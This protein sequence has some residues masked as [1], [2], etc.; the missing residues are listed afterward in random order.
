MDPF[1]DSTTYNH[2]KGIIH[3]LRQKNQYNEKYKLKAQE[4]YDRIDQTSVDN[5]PAKKVDHKLSDR[6]KLKKKSDVPEATPSTSG[7]SSITNSD[8]IYDQNNETVSNAEQLPRREDSTTDEKDTSVL[9]KRPEISLGVRTGNV[10]ESTPLVNKRV[11]D[12]ELFSLVLIEQKRIVKFNVTGNH[13]YLELKKKAFSNDLREALNNVY[14]IFKSLLDK[15]L[16]PSNL[17]DSDNQNRDLFAR[18]VI[19]SKFFDPPVSLRFQNVKNINADVVF[20]EIERIVRSSNSFE[21]DDTFLVYVVLCRPPVGT[22]KNCGRKEVHVSKLYLNKRCVI[23]ACSCPHAD[24][25]C[26]GRSIM[27][28]KA[29]ADYPDT[30]DSVRKRYLTNRFSDSI[31]EELIIFHRNAGILCEDRV[32]GFADLQKFQ[33]FL[34]PEYRIFLFEFV[35]NLPECT[36]FPQKTTNTE[37]KNI[38]IL[39]QDCHFSTI[40][41]IQRFVGKDKSYCVQCNQV[42]HN[43]TVYKH[44]DCRG[45]CKSCYHT[46]CPVTRNTLDVN[47]VYCEKCFRWFKND[48]CFKL[49]YKI[50]DKRVKSSCEM[51]YNCPRCGKFCK[52]KP[53]DDKHVCGMVKCTVCCQ[54][55]KETSD[56]QHVCFIQKYFNEDSECDSNLKKNRSKR[57][58]LFFFDIES[59]VYTGVHKPVCLIFCN[60]IGDSETFYG[61]DCIEQFCDRVFTTDF[62]DSIFLSHN[63]RSYDTW[64]ILQNCYKNNI[65]P[66]MIKSGS[67]ILELTIPGINLSFRDNLNFMLLKLE[68]LPKA[69]GFEVDSIKGVF[70]YTHPFIEDKHKVIMLPDRKYFC[71]ENMSKERLSQFD[72]WYSDRLENDPKYHYYKE[73]TSYCDN[74]VQILKKACIRFR[75]E[76][77]MTAGIC[78]YS[79]ALTLAMLSSLIYRKNY[80]PENTIGLIPS[81]GFPNARKYSE[82]STKWLE[83]LMTQDKTLDIKHARNGNERQ[84]KITIDN[85]QKSVYVDGYAEKNNKIQIFEFLGCFWHAHDS[86]YDADEYSPFLGTTFGEVYQKTTARLE[87]LK[88]HP[89]VSSVITIW[90]CEYDKKIREDDIFR[91]CVEGI[92]VDTPLTPKACLVGGRVES[93]KLYHEIS[94]DRGDRIRI[95]DIKS[96]YPHIMKSNFFPI[97]WPEIMINVDVAK[98]DQIYG[99]MKCTILP[100]RSLAVPVLP[101]KPSE[102]SQLFYPLCA[103]CSE[104]KQKICDHVESQRVL[105]STWTTP[106]LQLAVEYG[107]KIIRIIEAWHFGEKSNTLFSQFVCDYYATKVASEGFPDDI[108]TWDEQIAYVEKLNSLNGLNLTVS[109]I[110]KNKALRYLHKAVLNSLFGRFIISTDKLSQCK[111]IRDKRSFFSLIDNKEA[112]IKEID[113][114]GDDMLMVRYSD[115]YRRPPPFTNFVIGSFITSLARVHLYRTCYAPLDSSQ[116]LYSDTDSV[117]M[118]ERPGYPSLK[119]SPMEL[120]GLCDDIMS[121]FNV[122]DYA[123][124]FVSAAFKSYGYQLFHNDDLQ[125]LKIKGFTLNYCPLK[126]EQNIMTLLMLIKMV[127]ENPESVVVM[128]QPPLFHK[129][130]LTASITTKNRSKVF[131]FCFDRKIIAE[132]NEFYTTDGRGQFAY[133]TFPYGFFVKD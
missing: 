125:V 87:A 58:R 39:L 82:K 6:S 133:R 89:K 49:H 72:E 60:E 129:N 59:E 122:D 92:K 105:T 24:T 56:D 75:D 113:I 94:P 13:Y 4:A 77:I 10:N 19:T 98:F 112:D 17:A 8:V 21:L 47:P 71:P 131:S 120:G 57:R 11:L 46:S 119:T 43:R 65:K 38:Y 70:P 54:M 80:M 53:N 33:D 106:E 14:L 28:G 18:L 78:P 116:L 79:E 48:R 64:F 74:D 95:Y 123:K 41:C 118:I 30:S 108:T 115:R 34:F 68:Q 96:L 81:Y 117:F 5:F 36:F 45:M 50:P 2:V 1:K 26:L 88:A 99:V 91:S 126:S 29:L 66:E 76:T 63:G 15:V 121:T 32:Y 25:L 86:H 101:Y 109:Q 84:V 61:R 35:D 40:T 114:V 103:T 67:K 110:K 85:I 3:R 12:N 22:S 55:Y 97:G 62:A 124:I 127:I 52:G 73:M 130:A 37:A 20:T 102:S 7:Y 51:Y 93:F 83:F 31:S 111:F 90:E 23:D 69:M 100:P 42:Y 9:P 107:Y 104:L 16:D 128:L 27:L 132:D 44:F